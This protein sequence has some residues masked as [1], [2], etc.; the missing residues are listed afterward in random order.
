MKISYILYN[1]SDKIFG[2]NILG[3]AL[4]RHANVTPWTHLE[5]DR[6]Q[7][8]NLWDYYKHTE[9]LNQASSL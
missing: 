4:N 9:T 5:P 6:I 8:F 2:K 1:R 3:Y 7:N